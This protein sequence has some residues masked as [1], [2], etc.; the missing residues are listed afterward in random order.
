[1]ATLLC[2]EDEPVMRSAIVEVLTDEG[3]SVLEAEDGQVG[4]EKIAKHKPDLVVCDITMPRK[5]GYELL[6]DV[7]EA[8]HIFAEMPFIF[9]SA[10]ADR[11]HVIDGLLRGADD[12]VTKP[13]DFDILKMKIAAA[14]RQIE[15]VRRQHEAKLE[16]EWFLND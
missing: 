7:R 6:K 14:L 13:V 10:L 11:E 12:Y 5:N 9:L 3:Y 15:R 1:M 16:T 8:H 2:I 4:L